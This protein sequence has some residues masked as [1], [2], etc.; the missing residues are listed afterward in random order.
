VEDGRLRS[1]ALIEFAAQTA[2]ALASISRLESG[3]PPQPGYVGG[4]DSFRILGGVAAGTRL[5]CRVDVAVRFGRLLR[6]SCR[7]R[8]QGSGVFDVAHGEM[9]LATGAEDPP[10]QTCT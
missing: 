6:V 1:A 9:T 10:G 5:Q 8:R 2:A 7:V 4:I 3:H